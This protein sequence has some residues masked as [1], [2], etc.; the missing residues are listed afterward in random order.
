MTFSEESLR[1]LSAFFF[2]VTLKKIHGYSLLRKR[3]LLLTPFLKSNIEKKSMV[4]L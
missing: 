1:L 2:K 3:A 4:T